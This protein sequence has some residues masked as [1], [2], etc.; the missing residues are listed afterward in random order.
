[1][2]YFD[3]RVSWDEKLLKRRGHPQGIEIL[4]KEWNTYMRTRCGKT[5]DEYFQAESTLFDEMPRPILGKLDYPRGPLWDYM[6]AYPYRDNMLA[7]VSE[8]VKRLLEQLQ[9]APSEYV[10]EPVSVKQ[11]EV[12][13]YLLFVRKIVRW[14]D[15]DV[16]YKKSTFVNPIKMEIIPG[17]TEEIL[18]ERRTAGILTSPKNIVARKRPF[19]LD[20]ICIETCGGVFFSERLVNA[21]LQEGIVGFEIV[22]N[23]HTLTFV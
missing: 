19:Y 1:M 23:W 5:W 15:I 14:K 16:D 4:S 12:P 13:L 17:V 21:F 7:C 8:R 10:L 3:V 9:V 22:N 11:V 2:D 6:D 18:K 20:I